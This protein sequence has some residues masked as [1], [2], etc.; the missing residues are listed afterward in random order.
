MHEQYEVDLVE[1]QF[2]NNYFNVREGEVLFPLHERNYHSDESKRDPPV[3]VSLP[4]G[5]YESFENFIDDMNKILSDTNSIMEIY[6]NK[7]S[8][9]AILHDMRCISLSITLKDIL[10]LPDPLLSDQQ[11]ELKEQYMV[12]LDWDMKNLYLYADI[13]VLVLLEMLWYLCYVQS[14]YLTKSVHLY[15]DSIT[16]P[17]TFHESIF[18]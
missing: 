7:P 14:P 16:N 11:T 4:A 3:L 10:A 5:L 18:F 17:T 9:K 8:K 1:I 2:P 12:D 15:L 6:Y 13:A